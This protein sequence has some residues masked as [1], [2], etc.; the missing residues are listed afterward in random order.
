[1]K[2]GFRFFRLTPLL[3][4]LVAANALA[5]QSGEN[6]ASDSAASR[7]F[8]AGSAAFARQ[9]NRLAL[10]E[11]LAAIEAGSVGPA[12]HYNV[13][14]CYFR[15]GEYD[16]AESAFRV[17]QRD[18]PQMRSLADY[19]IG[20][21]LFRR[22]RWSAARDYFARAALAEDEQIAALANAMLVRLPL[23]GP[24]QASGAW[25]RVIDIRFGD[26]DNVA[27][28]DPL[29]LPAEITTDSS[30]AE[31]QFYAGGAVDVDSPW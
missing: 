10:T 24:V 4:S 28:I 12:V 22:D 8:A 11:F 15:L 25:T 3:F 23:A 1:L 29:S 17:L 16:L 21:T 20:L 14:V 5:Q 30:F 27:L 31:F 9:D 6:D 18:F 7:H 26:D 19:N 13:A 2:R